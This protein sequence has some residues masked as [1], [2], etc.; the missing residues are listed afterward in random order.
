M[1]AA[2][3]AGA[4]VLV[5]AWLSDDSKQVQTVGVL[6][7]LPVAPL[8]AGEEACQTPIGLADDLRRVRF[9]IGTQGKPGTALDVTVRAPSTQQVLGG[10][11][12]APGWVDNGTAQ[13]VA[14]GNIPGGRF[15][16]VCV[17]NRG[18][19]RAY[20][21]GDQ[22]MGGLGTGEVGVRPTVSTSYATVAGRRIRGDLSMQFVTLKPRSALSR[23]PAIFQR[24]SLFRP[25]GVGSWTYWMLLA[26]VVLLAPWWLWKALAATREDISPVDR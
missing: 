16:S 2:L 3:V 24:A 25:S 8:D 23:V 4:L 20:V 7:A 21:F 5:A 9:N 11:H 18:P 12:V 14:V 1:V 17:R 6:A 15:V 22:Y 13:N 19:V 26:G 10:G